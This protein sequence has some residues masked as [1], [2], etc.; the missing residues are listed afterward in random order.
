MLCC[1]HAENT[2]HA[3]DLLHSVG[4]GLSLVIVLIAVLRALSAACFQGALQKCSPCIQV[5]C[6]Y[7]KSEPINRFLVPPQLPIS[8]TVE[9]NNIADGIS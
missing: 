2:R 3:L 6:V 8:V 7:V 4:D 1:T 5:C 9:L